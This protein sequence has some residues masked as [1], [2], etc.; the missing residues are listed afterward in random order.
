MGDKE[1]VREK[2]SRQRGHKKFEKRKNRVR[3]G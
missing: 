1:R 3:E 2:V